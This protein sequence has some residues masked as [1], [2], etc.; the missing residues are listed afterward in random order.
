MNPAEAYLTELRDIRA[1]GAAVPETSGYGALAN[2]L[3]EVG[4]RLKPKV[5]CLINLQNAGAGIPDGGL[6]TASQFPKGGAEPLSGQLPARGA[7]EVKPV[8]GDARVVAESE[9]VRRYLEKYRQ[10]LVTTYR[11]FV[12]VGYDADRTPKLLESYSLS[13]TEVGFWSLAASPRKSAGESGERLCEFLKRCLLRQSQIASPQ[14][15]AWF[16]ASYARE[17]RARAEERDLPALATTRVALEEALGMDF[18]GEKGEHFFRS[19]LVQTLFYGLFAAWVFWAEHHEHTDAT[20]RFR[21]REAAG[22]LHI[23]ILQKLFY[24]FANPAQLGALHL[25]EVLDWAAEALNRVDRASFFNFF[26]QSHAVQYFYE[27]FLEAFDPEL[28]KE[29]GVWYTPPEI[30]TYMVERVDQVLRSEL[31]I[32]DG[33]ADPRVVVLDPC[34]GT[35]AYLVEV[36]GKIASTLRERGDDA[37]IAHDLKEAAK[38]RVFGFE[39]LPAP[40]VISHLQIG[41]LLH[42]LGAPLSDESDERAGVYLTNALTGWEPPTE[43]KQHLLFTEMEEERDKAEHVKQHAPILVILGNPPYNIFAGV[44]VAEERELSTAYL[45]TERVAA[46]EGRGLNDLY[47]RFFRMAERRVT[48]G[49]EGEGVVCFI[50]NY[51]WLDGLSHTGMRERYLE[52]FDKVWIDC[53]NGDK[54]K[55]GKLTPDGDPDP[56]VFSTEK[57]REGIQVGTAVTLLARKK[58]HE[59]AGAIRFRQHWGREKRRDL[60]Q[61]LASPEPYETLTPSL[62]VGLP[63]APSAFADDYLEWPMLGH[64]L[65]TSSPGVTTARDSFVVDIDRGRLDARMRLYF[66]SRVSDE[67]MREVASAALADASRFDGVAI[68]RKLVERGYLDRYIVP[69]AYRPFD[70]RWVYWEPDEKLLHEKREELFAMTQAGCH[71]L[72][73]RQK[74]ERQVEGPLFYATRR[75][76]DLHLTRPNTTCF[77]LERRADGQESLL[78]TPDVGLNLTDGAA[79]Y[80]ESLGIDARSDEASALWHHCA[81]LGYTPRY[82]RE[83][84]GALRQDW[85]RIPLPATR[86]ALLAS[87]ELG[88]T[89]AALL[90]VEEPV[91]AVTTGSVRH[92]LRPLGVLAAVSGRQLDPSAG[93]LAVTAGWGHGGKGGVTMPGRGRAVERPYTDVELAAFREGLAALGLTYDQLT[94]CLGGACY[95]VYLSDVA[96]WRCVPA[97]VWKYTIGGYQVMK[98]WLSYR[99]RAL[100]GRD[101]RPD[102]ARYVTEMTRRIAAILLLEPALD[103]NYERVKA[104]TYD[105]PGDAGGA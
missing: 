76:C 77:P 72:V 29:L 60:L 37:L 27:P 95:D 42:R 100:L 51:S 34:C 41:M 96:Y 83:N 32:A 8:G 87:A 97:R 50:S 46:P 17:A 63:F 4:G 44:A 54:Y 45:K 16:L 69:Y 30:V 105:W 18:T 47:V 84:A 49:T 7:I 25:D 22:Y 104:D 23:P 36:L 67:Q 79:D 81:A 21:W 94:A 59:P 98:K 14:D 2:L 55:S 53:L 52:V 90:D 91:D 103:E 65:P 85:P 20:A 24:D 40:F 13:P 33:L 62:G 28:R 86:D 92:E 39:I 15:L 6:F 1:S 19:T 12:L 78:A 9:Q 88:R 80:L 43:P 3:T 35:G 89:V 68:R 58:D 57:N 99:E 10:V 48:E 75:L 93:D 38:S 73:T 70:L 74:G 5:R 101:L 26:E 31:G 56:S 11:E 82:L 66:D 102:E 61:S 71:L 64:L